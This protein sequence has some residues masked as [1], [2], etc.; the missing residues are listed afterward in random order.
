[1]FPFNL[2][3]P[4]FLAFYAAF[5]A[6]ALVAYWYYTSPRQAPARSTRS[7]ELA[8]DPYK[9]ACLRGGEEEAI[10]L[11]I[12]NLVD[13]GLL[14][15][16]GLMLKATGVARSDALRIPLERA[17]VTHCASPTL[18]GALLGDRAVRAAC[19]EYD[20]DLQRKG[21]LFK[22]EERRAR[23]NALRVV[24]LLLG[25]I[26]FARILQALS[27]GRANIVFLIILTGIACWIAYGIYS[28]RITPAGNQALTNLATLLQRLKNQVSRLTP[29][30][31]TNEAVLL[32]AVFGIYALPAPAFPFVE[33]I[34]PR[35][36]GQ[37]DASGS[38]SFDSGGGGCGGGGGG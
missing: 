18:P 3:G 8:A 34:F 32:A 13:R 2:T 19:V 28:R 31:V 6:V 26:A 27:H 14:A 37:S 30:G 15:N 36:R 29:G 38:A 10:R 4:Q 11:S 17:I 21:L 23:L 7:Q 24:V 1:M 33:Q 16:D 5:S 25:G 12:V 35:P 22:D 9:I 20:K